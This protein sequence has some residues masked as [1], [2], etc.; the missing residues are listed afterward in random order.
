MAVD[1]FQQIHNKL[2]EVAQK[3]GVSTAGLETWA[4]TGFSASFVPCLQTSCSLFPHFADVIVI[5]RDKTGTGDKAS[6]A[7]TAFLQTLLGAVVQSPVKMECLTKI[8]KVRGCSRPWL[9]P[10]RPLPLLVCRV[11]VLPACALC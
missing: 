1:F 7:A 3:Y 8:M 9:M 6:A 2:T 11:L 4:T 10:H 5:R